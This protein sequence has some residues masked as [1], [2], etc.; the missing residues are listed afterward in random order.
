MFLAIVVLI[1]AGIDPIVE[2]ATQLVDLS[3]Q[4]RAI[5]A[6]LRM[7][8]VWTFSR[9]EADSVALEADAYRPRSCRVQ[10]WQWPPTRGN[11]A[12]RTRAAR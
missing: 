7:G 8:K 9:S 12:E 6:D 11:A 3:R 10:A 4:L 1:T 2:A 5:E